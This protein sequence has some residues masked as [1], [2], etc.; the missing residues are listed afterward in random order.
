MVAGSATGQVYVD[1]SAVGGAND[2]SSWS[3][4]YL[5]LQ[6]ALSEARGAG[7]AV[8]VWVAAGT[9]RPD[10]RTGDPCGLDPCSLGDESATFSLASDVGLYGGFPVG[11][12]AWE[13]R[14]P[15]ANVTILSGDLLGNDVLAPDPCL[16][17]LDPCAIVDDPCRADNSVHV[18]SASGTDAT[19]ILDGFVIEGGHS[20]DGVGAGINIADSDV[21]IR[22]CVLRRN[23][24]YSFVGENFGGGALMALHGS[25]LIEDCVFSGNMGSSGGAAKTL[26][27]FV[28]FARCR[29]ERNAVFAHSGGAVRIQ[30]GA[31]Q[32]EG[33][34]FNE[35]MSRDA[36][37]G[38]ISF[39]GSHVTFRACG[40]FWQLD[41]ER[42]RGVACEWRGDFVCGP[43]SL[44]GDGLWV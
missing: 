27:S 3:D 11:G 8:D 37:G 44:G 1:S 19:A 36:G 12:G 13:A 34:E 28:T 18:V 5:Y 31:V 24:A 39:L 35:N 14:D 21:V 10:E 32:F 22:N 33:C 38:A 25:P 15:N 43:G 16:L 42:R 40:F 7:E 41:A 17:A 30:N 26:S 6:D 2:G 29:F 9:Y 23:V 4:A 20:P